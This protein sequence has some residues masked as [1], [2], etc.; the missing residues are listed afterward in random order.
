MMGAG[1]ASG[2]PAETSQDEYVLSLGDLLRVI[3][4]R[5]WVIALIAILSTGAALGY[6]LG[7]TPVYEAS[8]KILV[9]Q[10]GQS[11][12]PG[13]LGGEVQ[14]LQQITL[15]MSEAVATRPVADAVIDRL[16]LNLTPEEFLENL[17]VEQVGNTQFIQVSYSDPNPERARRVANTVGEVFADQVSEVSPSANSITATL[18]ERAI[19]PESPASPNVLLNTLLA[20]VLGLMLGVGLAFLMEYLDDS[21]RSPEEVEQISGVPT[22]GIIPEFKVPKGVATGNPKGKSKGKKG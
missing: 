12:V 9:G 15:T 5:W 3:W 10:E 14:G 17:S 8:I 18:W 7:Q 22:F 13:G 21:W 2:A 4:K 1:P 11:N 20:L 16:D 19:A 6:S